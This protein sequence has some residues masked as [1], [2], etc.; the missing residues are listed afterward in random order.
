MKALL[1]NAQVEFA[2]TRRFSRPVVASR[3]ISTPMKLRRASNQGA[4]AADKAAIET[5]QLQLD[6][7]SSSPPSTAASASA[8]RSRQHRHANST[9]PYHQPVQPIAV[10][11]TLPKMNCQVMRKWPPTSACSSTHTTAATW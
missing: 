6:W 9:N 5:A 7:C 11:F 10:Y 8:G 1:K 3:E 2:A 4:I